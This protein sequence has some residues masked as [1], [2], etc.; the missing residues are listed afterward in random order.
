VPVH[1][2]GWKIHG[3][4]VNGP[5]VDARDRHVAVAW[6]TASTSDGE[7][8]IAFSD[9]AGRTFSEPVRVDDE[10]CSGHL[11]VEL[12]P[13]GSAAVSWTELADEHAQVKVRRIQRSGSRSPSVRVAQVS[14]AEYPR[15]AHG[16]DELLLA[17]SAVENGSLRVRTA[18]AAVPAMT[19]PRR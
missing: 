6:F 13:D 15:L 7:A 2:D 19:S 16:R 14:N 4:P 12:L 17:W 10:A 9:D 18:R 11:D 5:A 1:N 3:C 8:F